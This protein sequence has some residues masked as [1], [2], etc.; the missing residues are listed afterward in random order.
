MFDELHSAV[1]HCEAFFV[2]APSMVYQMG[3]HTSQQAPTEVEGKVTDYIHLIRYHVVGISHDRNFIINMDQTPVYLLMNAKRILKVIGTKTIHICTSTNNT[4]QV[5]DAVTI[6]ADGMVLGSMLV[7]KG[8]PNGH[9]A[10]N[11]FA[12]FPPT[13]HYRCQPNT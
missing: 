11:E 7:F 8:Q 4:R 3:V 9:I 1:Q 12:M 5:M 13:H 6:T 10:R 2:K